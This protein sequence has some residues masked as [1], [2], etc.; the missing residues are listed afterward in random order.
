MIENK[1]QVLEKIDYFLGKMNSTRKEQESLSD[2]KGILLSGGSSLLIIDD[3]ADS[4][5]DIDAY[6][7]KTN[8]ELDWFYNYLLDFADD[9]DINDQAAKQ[10]PLL[11][12]MIMLDKEYIFID[13]VYNFNIY[14]PS[15]ETLILTKVLASCS[16]YKA[17]DKKDLDIL[18]SKEYDSNKLNSLSTQW[19]DLLKEKEGESV[20]NNFSSHFNKLVHK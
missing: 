4:T 15:I 10:L 18:L 1:K 17:K 16:R 8:N 5:I 13:R 7:V 2:V 12:K 3:N 11:T 14:T 20:S 6:L 9:S 19:I